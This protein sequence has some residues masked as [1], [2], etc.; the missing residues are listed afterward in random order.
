MLDSDTGSVTDA[1]EPAEEA[2]AAGPPSEPP[3]PAQEASS[4]PPAE[5]DSPQA[6][7]GERAPSPTNRAAPENEASTKTRA[8]APLRSTAAADPQTLVEVVDQLQAAGALSPAEKAELVENLKRSDPTIW[9]QLVS[10]FRASLDRRK[11]SREAPPARLPDR[12]A[13][14]TEPAPDAAVRISDLPATGEPT[15]DP[16]ASLPRP[17]GADLA[18]R[19]RP[20]AEGDGEEPTAK[21]PSRPKPVRPAPAGRSRE[22]P[23]VDDSTDDGWRAAL[24]E[25]IGELEEQLADQ[26]GAD[27]VED[28][29]RLRLLHLAAG[30]RDEALQPIPGAPEATQDFWSKELFGLHAYLDSHGRRS[31]ARRASEALSHLR[32]ASERLSE[33]ASLRVRNLAVCTR[34]LGYGDYRRFDK[35]EFTPGQEVVLYAELENFTSRESES[36]YSTSLRCLVQVLDERGAR[37]TSESF[38]VHDA[39]RQNI[40]RDFYLS[41]NFWMPK[42]I[43]GGSYAIQLRVEDE[44]GDKADEATVD[45]VV[46]PR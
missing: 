14:P 2:A 44:L 1:P 20:S 15:E 42:A 25:A 21:A 35:Y 41:C 29:A 43:S 12:A 31:G 45:V 8:E 4:H 46:K 36:G 38:K 17:A 5:E 19:L 30:A 11:P 16:P 3:P 6:P 24:R 37:I 28:H 9:P 7:G 18:E 34:V 33:E 23:P 10:Y 13:P 27:H 39:R 22:V 26:R 32:Q 40:R